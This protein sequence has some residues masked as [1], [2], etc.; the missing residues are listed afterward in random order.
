MPV[1][2]VEADQRIK[3]DADKVAIQRGPIIFC[4]EWPD[5][6]DGNILNLVIDKDSQVST[7][8]KPGLL[9]GTQVIE[10]SGHQT[11][12]TPDGR[13]DDLADEEITLIPYALWNNRGPGQMRVWLPIS[14]SSAK[15][16]RDTKK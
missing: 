9:G 2:M 12:R 5:N 4:A 16:L 10:L 11:V 13:I 6:K 14:D 3:D 1:R 7:G 15:P 8:F